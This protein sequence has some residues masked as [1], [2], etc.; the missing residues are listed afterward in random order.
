MLH[1]IPIHFDDH[2]PSFEE[3][4]LLQEA[5]KRQ[6]IFEEQM[7]IP[8]FVS[9]D[10][11]LVGDALLWVIEEFAELSQNPNGIQFCEWGCAHGV[12]SALASIYGVSSKGIEAHPALAEAAQQLANDFALPVEIELGNFFP[13]DY[14]PPADVVPHDH[15]IFREGIPCDEIK[16][17]APTNFDLIYCY[18]WPQEQ[19]MIKH[20]FETTTNPNTLF[21]MYAG[22]EDVRLYQNKP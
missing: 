10:F 16:G 21:L 9:A 13:S 1:E 8:N 14:T 3:E 20:L 19:T 12:V 18:P 15:E 6:V 7:L 2:S 5:A 17:M 11:V 4:T 22:P